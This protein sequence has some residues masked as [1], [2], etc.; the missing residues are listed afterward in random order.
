MQSNS[1]SQSITLGT[2][3]ESSLSLFGGSH[4][5]GSISYGRN[6]SS[7]SEFGIAG[8]PSVLGNSS[9]SNF[10][11]GWGAL[12]SGFPTLHATY[13]ISDSTSTLLGTTDKGKSSSKS[14]NLNSNYSIA[15]FNLQGTLGHYSTDFLSPE[16]S[17]SQQPWIAPRRIRITVL[18][19]P[20]GCRFPVTW[21][22]G[23]RERPRQVKRTNFRVIPTRHRPAF[24]PG[25]DCRSSGLWNYTTN[26]V[27]AFEQS[28]R[29]SAGNAFGQPRFKFQCNLYEC[30]GDLHGGS[31]AY[32][33]RLRKPSDPAS[34]G[35]EFR[36]YAIRRHRKLPKSEQPFRIFALLH[37]RCGYGNAG[38]Q[39]RHRPGDKSQHDAQV[40]PM[41][42]HSGLRLFSRYPDSFW[43]RNNEQLQLWRH[44]PTQ[45][46]FVHELEYK[47]PGN[48]QRIGGARRHQQSCR[49]VHLSA[50]DS[51]RRQ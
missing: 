13:S 27:L 14:F 30:H 2:G 38:W 49:F 41:G 21:D 43:Y 18:P 33:Y 31:W 45:D 23:G 36:E 9:G 48:T 19:R 22:W 11:I 15:G 17:D 39:R 34:S 8:V 7:N 5:P 50:T 51:C 47:L 1:D 26:A 44:D 29:G 46:P 16:F 25:Q 10:S 6:F 28:P 40:R 4:F 42:S 20:T 12:F 24:R 35:G 32:H 3:V 37:R